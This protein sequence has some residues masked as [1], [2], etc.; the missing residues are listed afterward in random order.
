MSTQR[1]MPILLIVF[2]VGLVL[3]SP[4]LTAFPAVLFMI[5]GLATWWQRQSLKEVHY[6]RRLRYSRGFPDETLQVEIEVE[7]RKILPLTWLHIQDPWPLAVGPADESE[8][9]YSHLPDLGLLVH[10]FSLRWYE[11]AR[12]TYTLLLR[13]RG[14]YPVGSALARSGDLFG[15]YEAADSVGQKDQIT[16]FPHLLLQRGEQLPP[17]NPLGDQ[18]SHRRLLDDPNSPMGVR[19]YLPED[20][21]RRVH[22]PA[23]AR[24]GQLQVKVYQPTCAE[25]LVV[26]LNV[27]TYHRHWEGYYPALF[28]HMLSLTATTICQAI[29]RGNRVGLLSNGSQ[30]NADQPYHIAPGRSPAQLSKLLTALAGAAPVP[31]VGFER[32]LLREIPKVPYGSSLLILTAIV[33][34]ELAETLLTLKKHERKLTLLSLAEEAPPFIPGIACIH[35]P[36]VEAYG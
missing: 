34:P 28:E 17:V 24:T 27:A 19:E 35:Q 8:I 7:N 25:V 1:W 10:V 20:S 36:F 30:L 32:F 2:F 9:S 15:L 29:E 33:S 26:C 21:F 12:R 31:A 23:T 11:L 22:W 14:I 18:R 4:Y 5:I 3:R 6:R 13:K 16:V